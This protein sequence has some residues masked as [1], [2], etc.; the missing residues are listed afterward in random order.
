MYYHTGLAIEGYRIISQQ[1][2]I[3]RGVT[4]F[5]MYV[6]PIRIQPVRISLAEAVAHFPNIVMLIGRSSWSSLPDR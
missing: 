6:H 1:R 4:S 5:H 2:H 3:P